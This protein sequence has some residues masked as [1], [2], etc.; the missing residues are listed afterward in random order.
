[1]EERLFDHVIGDPAFRFGLTF[2]AD[3]RNT[4]L[5]WGQGV[6]WVDAEPV[7]FQQDQ[8]GESKPLYWTWIDLLEFLG[9]NWAWLVHEENYPFHLTPLDPTRLRGEAQK[10]WE[11]LPESTVLDEDEQVF[12][13]ERRHNL[14]SG[15]KGVFLPEVSVLREGNLAWVCAEGRAH[16]LS[17]EQVLGVLEKVGDLI[18]ERVAESGEPRACLARELWLNR[19]KTADKNS[20]RNQNRL[21]VA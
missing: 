20:F 19:Q 10:R 18:A 4:D 12:R 17:L 6:L 8:E 9:R 3:T 11:D 16:R 5:A 2:D 14:A 21:A 15:M 1:M 13:F 7:W